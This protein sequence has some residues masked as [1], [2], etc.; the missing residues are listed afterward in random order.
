MKYCAPPASAG[1]SV[2]LSIILTLPFSFAAPLY[3]ESFDSAAS[4]K[5]I[6]NKL[7]NADL[8]Y[9]DY[10]SFVRDQPGG[11]GPVT[12]KIPE[13]P[14]RIPGSTATRGIL[15]NATYAGTARNINI[16]A[17]TAPLGTAASFSD[18]YRMSFDLWM[19]IDPTATSGTTEVGLFGLGQT[20]V[21]RASLQTRITGI[22]TYGWLSAE[23]G[24]GGA[25]DMSLFTDGV[26]AFI[27]DLPA[28][29]PDPV[30]FTL[31]FA[32]ATPAGSN[33]PNNQ[34]SNVV[35]TVVGTT[36]TV[37]ING[38]KFGETTN[39]VNTSGIAVLGYEDPFTGSTPGGFNKQ[40]AIFDNW[41][42]DSIA[43]APALEAS[44]TSVFPR[45]TESA[46]ESIGGFS[47]VNNNASVSYNILSAVIDGPNGADFTPDPVF[48]AT[49]P[50]TFPIVVPPLESVPLSVK[51]V[52][53]T[54]NGLKV[55]RLTLTTSDP[56]FPVI[57][58]PLQA[59]RDIAS[60][61]ASI[62]TRIVSVAV[63]GGTGNGILTVTNNGPAAVTISNPQLTGTDASM[64]A[65]IST[66]PLMIPSL[67]SV[68]LPVVFTPTGLSG[69]KSATLGL[70]STDAG[71]PTLSI[72]LLSRYAFGPP[73]LAHYKMDDASGTALVDATGVSPAAGLQIRQA[74]FGFQQ[75]S[76]LPG[77]AG[78]SVRLIA[79]ESS[80]VGNFAI[81]NAVH[82]PNVSYSMW[83]KPEA[84]ANKR[85]LLHRSSLF[86]TVGT[87]YALYLTPAGKLVFEVNSATAVESAEGAIPD[88][89]VS[90]IAV[91]HSDLDGF[92]N[93][94]A[95][96][97]R[98]FI[99]GAVVA[100]TAPV[101]P[102]VARGYTDYNLNTTSAGLYLGTTTSAGNTGYAGLVDDL[103]IYSVELTPG[104]IAGMFS[105]PGKTAFNL[106]TLDYRITSV[107]YNP[108]TGAVTLTWSSSAGAIYSVQQSSTTSGFTDVPGQTGIASGGVTTTA[109]FTAAAGPRRFFQ[110]RRT[111]PP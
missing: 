53:S 78:T 65:L 77:G 99:N 97:T 45:V 104:T 73:L 106:E 90:H 43:A 59:T 2:L 1:I 20:A 56:N 23:G 79:A 48:P 39:A 28:A 30:P 21:S 61:L 81:S 107:Q 63:T 60:L 13:A 17:A 44:V 47:V 35:V 68:E 51:F 93:T 85:T 52:P 4:A 95:T 36:V 5:V 89:V 34:W 83:I 27:N 37:F 64:F 9:V 42:I 57:V 7:A 72:P 24:V 6:V 49:V 69:L 109:S 12:I 54:P 8:A 105:Q 74:P 98:L 67:E 38:V 76:L 82:L 71:V 15:L 101:D 100:E 40:F 29:P 25:G 26:P 33:A 88:D 16:L 46:Q 75:T 87:L 91:T 11:G 31:A 110:I 66:F 102:E 86:T 84:K 32:Q 3:T 55:A 22:G 96:R 80:T 10:S 94:T 108:A 70:T 62:T 111:S 92:G 41:K 50:P 18:N 103:Q 58:L 14:N 19:A